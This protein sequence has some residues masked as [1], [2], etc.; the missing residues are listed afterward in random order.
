MRIKPLTLVGTIL[1][2]LTTLLCFVTFTD[3][4]GSFLWVV[5]SFQAPEPRM[6]F[7]ELTD[8]FSALVLSFGALA[9][10]PV[11]LFAKSN[12]LKM[13]ITIAYAVFGPL[14]S[15]LSGFLWVG[16]GDDFLRVFFG[17]WG[18]NW[19]RSFRVISAF[20]ALAGAVILLLSFRG[21]KLA[22]EQAAPGE[23]SA[24]RFDPETGL[25]VASAQ[26]AQPVATGG[27]DSSLPLVALILAFFI[28]LGAVIV[29]HIAMNQMNQGLI[30]SQ[31]R[32]MAKAGL[33]LGYVFIGLSMLLGL[34]FGIVYFAMLQRAYY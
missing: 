6:V 20:P 4:Q 28:P 30:S 25:P 21:A 33:I 7:A 10:V 31:N 19:E 14:L 32:G 15:F 17:T 26:V 8:S 11:V 3:L 23:A 24:P 13:F 1:V 34:I 22:S 5:N 29:G 18:E 9:L 27:A 12:Q 2:A 16:I